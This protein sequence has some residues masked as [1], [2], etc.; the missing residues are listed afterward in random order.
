MDAASPDVDAA[1]RAGIAIYDAG[2]YH[3]A[4]DAWEARWL[5]LPSGSDDERFLHG[6]IQF[7][8][9][10]HHGRRE[11]WK[12]VRGLAASA[13]EYLAGLPEDYRG[14]NLD[15]VRRFLDRA[16]TDPAMID[17]DRPLALT[18]HGVALALCDLDDDAALAAAPALAG[19][20]NLDEAFVEATVAAVRTA[21][22]DG[23]TGS[24]ADGPKS[25]KGDGPGV[26]NADG[27]DSTD[28]ETRDLLF[29][30]VRCAE[31]REE[32]ARSLRERESGTDH[33]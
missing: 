15:G 8:A 11:N 25:S 31:R 30:F 14:V 32:V 26:T 27:S 19:E 3:A 20:F 23:R 24:N 17:W 10:V 29:D 12:G 16:A 9:V 1:L 2:F 13:V 18:C 4:H 5:S 28:R 33:R 22:A 7:T 21:N 6:L